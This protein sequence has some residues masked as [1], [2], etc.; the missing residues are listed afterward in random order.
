M[1]ARDELLIV[2]LPRMDEPMIVDAAPSRSCR[3][4]P[5]PKTRRFFA[6][7]KE[8]CLVS[9]KK[10][11]D[12]SYTGQIAKQAATEQGRLLSAMI[13]SGRA[14]RAANR[15]SHESVRP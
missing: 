10:T 6:D 5:R 3:Y 13:A 12:D 7:K 15:C 11:P 8:I 9:G 4:L 14:P 2:N 1:T